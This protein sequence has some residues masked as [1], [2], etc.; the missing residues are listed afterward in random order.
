MV[1]P[2]SPTK[3]SIIPDLKICRPDPKPRHDV[4]ASAKL[5]TNSNCNF[6]PGLV[7]PLLYDSRELPNQFHRDLFENSQ[8]NYMANQTPNY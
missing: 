6:I 1:N 8:P 4:P 3:N 7:G 2:S 5:S